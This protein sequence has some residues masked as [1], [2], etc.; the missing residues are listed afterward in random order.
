MNTTILFLMYVVFAIA[1]NV[2]SNRED[3]EEE[4]YNNKDKTLN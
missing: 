4:K 3:K 1:Y 2:V